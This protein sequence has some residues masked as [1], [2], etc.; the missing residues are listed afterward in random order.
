MDK[1][2]RFFRNGGRVGDMPTLVL[3]GD[4]DQIVPIGAS[5]FDDRQDG[6]GS[7]AESV[8]GFSARDAHH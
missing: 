7:H 4:D 8:S 1:R 2:W 6:E 5:D 3:H